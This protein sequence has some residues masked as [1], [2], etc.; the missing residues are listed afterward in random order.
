M[1]AETVAFDTPAR[2]ATSVIDGRLSL[3]AR[4]PPLHP[5]PEQ[6]RTRSTAFDYCL[7]YGAGARVSSKPAYSFPVGY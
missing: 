7:G 3:S 2:R 6:L 1:T 5:F 4:T